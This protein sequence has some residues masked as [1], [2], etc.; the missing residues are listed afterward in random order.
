M[1]WKTCQWCGKRRNGSHQMAI[2]QS[3]DHPAEK[4]LFDQEQTV[5]R[6]ERNLAREQ[7]RL[8]SH[9][10]LTA[11]LEGEMPALVRQ[12]ITNTRDLNAYTPFG[13]TPVSVMELRI[14]EL[15]EAL[16]QQQVKLAQLQTAQEAEAVAALY[17]QEV[18]PDE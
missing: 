12:A 13:Q 17:N 4:R 8:E 9:Q 15:T 14:A 16:E 6:F 1:A 11:F 7:G 2:H 3:I 10:V 18:K 5:K